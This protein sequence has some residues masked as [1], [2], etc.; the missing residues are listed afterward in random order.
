LTEKRRKSIVGARARG[1]LDEK[2]NERHGECQ[3]HLRYGSRDGRG[4]QTVNS[5]KKSG[6]EKAEGLRGIAGRFL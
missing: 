6:G 4:T 1:K 2:K 3:R 5:E